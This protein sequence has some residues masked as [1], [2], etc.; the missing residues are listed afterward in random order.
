MKKKFS[1]VIIL[2]FSIG[3]AMIY[4]NLKS[5]D[6]IETIEMKYATDEGL[7]KNYSQTDKPEYLL[8]STGLYMELL[9]QRKEKV[10]FND[11]VKVLKKF[12]I[13]K[14]DNE[15]FM[16]WKTGSDISV[17]AFID[18]IRIIHILRQAADIF[19]R[20]EYRILAD[21][22]TQPIKEYQIINNQIPHYYDWNSKYPAP[23]MVNSYLHDDYL[24]ILV[25]DRYPSPT[26]DGLFFA[27]EQTIK[28]N[29]PISSEEA[30]MVDQLLIATY[31]IDKSCEN[32]QFHGWLKKQWDERK[33]INGRYNKKNG[34]PTVNY[35]SRAVYALA[36]L[37]FNKTQPSIAKEILKRKS[38]F[39]SN[40]TDSKTHFFDYVHGVIVSYEE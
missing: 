29:K 26:I 14:V 7:I 24:K 31:C 33:L 13:V 37:Y 20:Q 28:N 32:P 27:E 19:D 30:H 21:E 9:L 3:G 2:I 17:N 39:F 12:F 8:E 35:E 4:L 23:T 18:D 25:L 6:A 16:K 10:R 11:Q 22:L 15:L 40:R 34:E 5:L 38:S 1:I 36:V